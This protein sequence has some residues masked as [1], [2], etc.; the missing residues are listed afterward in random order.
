MTYGVKGVVSVELETLTLTI[1]AYDESANT[2]AMNEEL[3]LL[4][5]RRPDSQL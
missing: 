3:D 1:T 2:D 4:V 5:E